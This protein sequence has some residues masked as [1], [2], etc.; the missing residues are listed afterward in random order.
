M[1]PDEFI[2]RAVSAAQ[3]SVLKALSEGAAIDYSQRLRVPPEFMAEVWALV[4]K[5][6]LKAA[7][8]RRLET[9]LAD[10]LVNHIAAEMATDIKSI[11][12]VQERREALRAIARQHVM[13]VLQL[14]GA[15]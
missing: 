10:R 4:D 13:S 6:A 2:E 3:A 15:A 7:L 1:S 14:G 12:S 11:L 8:A 9:E 5:D